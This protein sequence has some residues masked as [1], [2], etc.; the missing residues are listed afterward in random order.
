MRVLR[1]SQYKIIGYVETDTDGK[2]VVRD[3][4]Y[5]I[6]GY[7]NPE[8]DT[9]RDASYRLIGYGNL[10]GGMSYDDSAI[11]HAS[12]G[13]APSQDD[14]GAGALILLVLGT[15][16]VVVIGAVSWAWQQINDYSSLD[17]PYRF[18]ASYYFYIVAVPIRFGGTL[19]S[20]LRSPGLTQYTN[21]N[22]IIALGGVMSY[23]AAIFVV[24]AL[25]LRRSPAKRWFAVVLL[26]GPATLALM[27][28]AGSATLHW[29]LAPT[30]A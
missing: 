15:A 1:N 8:T 2:Q 24:L 17:A 30:P 6:K 18:I 7:Y 5:H 10:L 16:L 26:L 13:Y 22:L 11:S 9:T 19:F 27:Y 14:D 3:A 20:F 12:E 23:A 29:L 21:L 4:S 25:L 28:F